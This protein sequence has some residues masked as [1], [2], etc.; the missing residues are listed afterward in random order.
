M[1]QLRGKIK[2]HQALWDE[3]HSVSADFMQAVTD[4]M[5]DE[6]H[7]LSD[8]LDAL[9]GE[10]REVLAQAQVAE[11]CLMRRLKGARNGLMQTLAE[12]LEDDDDTKNA[13]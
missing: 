3:Y 6:A 5:P 10:M 4:R 7:I 13:V 11:L 8:S 1:M 2:E 12:V 9:A